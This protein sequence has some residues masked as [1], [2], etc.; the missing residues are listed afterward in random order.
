MGSD[1]NLNEKR[2]Q[3]M[4]KFLELINKDKR[5]SKVVDFKNLN[6]IDTGIRHELSSY[7]KHLN[8]YFVLRKV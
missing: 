2:N 6:Q 5:K 4:D 3:S 1:Q 7:I 8:G